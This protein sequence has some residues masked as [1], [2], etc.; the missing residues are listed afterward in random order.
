VTQYL[1]ILLLGSAILAARETVVAED[2]THTTSA[3][4]SEEISAGLPKFV[5]KKDQA[6]A[7]DTPANPAAKPVAADPT[8]SVLPTVTVRETRLPSADR[9]LTYE[10]KAEKV[11]AAYMGDSDGLDRGV[12]NRYTL[13]QLWQKIP[14]LGGLPFVGTPVRMTNAERAYDRSGA[15]DKLGRPVPSPNEPPE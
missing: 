11:V 8:I 15:N 3:R 2:E 7:P 6:P 13:K 14:F 9:V 1:K 4:I 12:L 10:G 5:P